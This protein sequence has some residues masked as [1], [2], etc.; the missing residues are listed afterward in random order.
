MTEVPGT[1]YVL[2]EDH[3][4]PDRPARLFD[5]PIRIIRCDAP[6]DVPAALDAM[7]AA[8]ADGHYL[9][10]FLAYELGY[11]LEPKLLPLLPPHRS[12]PLIWMGI[13]PHCREIAADGSPP[14]VPGAPSNAAD[15]LTLS[16]DRDA[17]LAAFDR[18][19][20]YIVAGDVYQINLTFKYRFDFTGDPVAFY[21]DL[22]REQRVGHAALIG[23]EDFHVLSL[24]PELF[25]QTRGGDA[26]MRPMKGTAPRGRTLEEDRDLKRMLIADEKSRA[27]NLMILDLMRNDLGRL[28]EI[29]SVSVTDMFRV[30]TF[31]SLHQMTSGV[32]ARL[33]D[34]VDLPGLIRG[35]FPCGSVTGAPKIRAM[36]IIRDLETEPRGVY[37][38][39]VGMIAPNGDVDLN[40][41]IRTIML[42]GAGQGELGIGSGIVFDSD[43]LAEY[44]ESLL[45][46]NFMT[47]RDA[48]FELIETM[49][50]DRNGGYYL[51]DEHLG[52]LLESAVYF[53]FACDVDAVRRALDS[54]AEAL[55]GPC[56]RVRLTLDEYGE[57]DLTTAAIDAP[58]ADARTRYVIAEEAT[59]SA[60][61][62]LFHK[63]TRRQFYDRTRE[64]LIRETGCDEA[65][66]VN[67]KGELT[68]GSYTN[69][70]VERDGRLLTPP[71][72]CGLLNGTLR[73]ALLADPDCAIEEA[74]LTPVDLE[75]ADRVYLGNSVR[76]LVRAEPVDAMRRAG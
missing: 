54:V 76:G 51:L 65:V 21:N 10:G 8:N 40:V 33:R 59:D 53:G 46:A 74:V 57:I 52:R 9:A 24:S 15:G 2:L 14:L 44:A 58:S 70:F 45:K 68:E 56:H 34:D 73:R 50:W 36:E 60:N 42:D 23:A 63:T 7:A 55:G 1:P 17:Y 32:S 48:P 69:L 25:L 5:D 41:A 19:K 16:I 67:E 20:D 27:E 28:A 35:I 18:V 6:E 3:L 38:G 62:F 4:D 37:T 66:F 39:A 75:T 61:R 11:V 31:R 13:F 71:L 72:A 43:G 12:Q 64:R 49:R 47:G 26:S 22:R 29:G 30:E